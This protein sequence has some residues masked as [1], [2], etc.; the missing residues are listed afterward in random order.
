MHPFGNG[1]PFLLLVETPPN[2]WVLIAF[3]H[4][5]HRFFLPVYRTPFLLREDGGG[6]SQEQVMLVVRGA[7]A[8]QVGH[9]FPSC[10]WLK[11]G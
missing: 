9:N 5:L 2:I 1:A 3:L 6:G 11:T 7:K 4:T 10:F 8:A